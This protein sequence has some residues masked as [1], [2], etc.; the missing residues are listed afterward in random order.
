[1]RFEGLLDAVQLASSMFLCRIPRS[2][3]AFAADFFRMHRY[4]GRICARRLEEEEEVGRGKVAIAED[5][6]IG[7]E[8]YS[9]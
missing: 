5:R 2:I 1:M 8:L 4:P 3:G 6:K 7:P 9:L